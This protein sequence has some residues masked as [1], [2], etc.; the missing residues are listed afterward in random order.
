[1][2]DPVKKVDDMPPSAGKSVAAAGLSATSGVTLLLYVVHIFGI[3]DM[4]PE[5]AAAII[6]LSTA[7][8][9]AV[10]HHC[11]RKTERLEKV[12]T[13]EPNVAQNPA[14]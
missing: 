7:A 3:N 14:S 1:M 11:Q 10:M 5:V 8:A 6:G 9:G 2:A 12:L 13:G 4:P